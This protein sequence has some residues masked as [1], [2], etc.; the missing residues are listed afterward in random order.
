[1]ITIADHNRKRWQIVDRNVYKG[2]NSRS[3][4]VNCLYP[5]ELIQIHHG[6]EQKTVEFVDWVRKGEC[7]GGG[8]SWRRNSSSEGCSEIGSGGSSVRDNRRIGGEFY[9]FEVG[10]GNARLGSGGCGKLVRD[11]DGVLCSIGGCKIASSFWL[12]SRRPEM[13]QS[14]M[15][16]LVTT[17]DIISKFSQRS[18]LQLTVASH[19]GIR[20]LTV[21]LLKSFSYQFE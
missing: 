10:A 8:V 9:V 2:G 20:V 4:C 21:L 11:C 6:C 16:W 3:C 1:M 13:K 19:Q 12:S 15:E 17:E 5:P 14:R 18:Q 7:I